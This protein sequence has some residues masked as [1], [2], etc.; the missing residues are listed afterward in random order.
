MSAKYERK[1]FHWCL[2]FVVWYPDTVGS[3]IRMPG[4]QTMDGTRAFGNQNNLL[5]SNFPAAVDHLLVQM[6]RFTPE[7][8]ITTM[9]YF[10]SLSH[11]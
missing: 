3:V 2:V 9:F 5:A 10:L 8:H 1:Q 7:S 4:L 11:F 6:F